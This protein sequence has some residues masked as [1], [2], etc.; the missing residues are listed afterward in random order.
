MA[1]CKIRVRKNKHTHKQSK[2]QMNK[3][4]KTPQLTV[5]PSGHK[6]KLNE[7]LLSNL[8]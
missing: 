6:K 1:N 4:T 5:T 3:Q 8:P 2:N 7:I